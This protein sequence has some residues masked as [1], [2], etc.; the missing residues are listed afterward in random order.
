MLPTLD[1]SS[2]CREFRIRPLSLRTDRVQIQH[3][4]AYFVV[5]GKWSGLHMYSVSTH[6]CY[7]KA[8]A[9]PINVLE[10]SSPYHTAHCHPLTRTTFQNTDPGY[11]SRKIWKFRT[12]KFDLPFTWVAWDKIYVCFTY[13]IYPLEN[14]K[15]SA[16]VSAVAAKWNC[17]TG[18]GSDTALET[19]RRGRRAARRPAGGTC[20]VHIGRLW[21]HTQCG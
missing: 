12:D 11:M 8:W 9:N 20:M 19:R 5:I 17:N 2:T 4:F 6:S 1:I 15:F 13:R 21:L 18:L 3:I 16:R 14:F 10:K 7:G